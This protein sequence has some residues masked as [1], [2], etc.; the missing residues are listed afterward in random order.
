MLVQLPE[1]NVSFLG[2]PESLLPVGLRGL[3]CLVLVL[4]TGLAQVRQLLL[5]GDLVPTLEV[6]LV[7][8]LVQLDN[9]NN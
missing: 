9:L 3:R 1:P 7:E 5:L 2:L 4:L 6:E 8:G